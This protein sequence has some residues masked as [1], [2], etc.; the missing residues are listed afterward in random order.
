MNGP[1]TD[2]I[3]GEPLRAPAFHGPKGGSMN[4]LRF[5]SI[6]LFAWA[7]V[8]VAAATSPTNRPPAGTLVPTPIEREMQTPT[9]PKRC[10]PCTLICPVGKMV[11]QNGHCE[12]RCLNLPHD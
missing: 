3:V 4:R 6:A 9:S 10:E 7:V 8:S 1:T 5:P 11:L 2:L 12:C